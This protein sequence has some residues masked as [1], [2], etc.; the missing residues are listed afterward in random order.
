MFLR[1][2]IIV[3]PNAT[4]LADEKAWQLAPTQDKMGHG[5]PE[6]ATTR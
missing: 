4:D 5:G 6:N 2:S 3:L 1:S